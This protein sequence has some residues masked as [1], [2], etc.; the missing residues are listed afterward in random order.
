MCWVSGKA[1][2]QIAERDF[3]VYKIGRVPLNNIFVSHLKF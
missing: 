2:E 3:Y 1:I